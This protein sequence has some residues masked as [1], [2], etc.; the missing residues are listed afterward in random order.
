MKIP[1]KIPKLRRMG[2][3]KTLSIRYSEEIAERFQVLKNR[4]G[5]IS[6]FIED[7]VRNADITEAEL[8]A[9]RLLRRG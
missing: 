6:K 4:P 5:G 8:E 9:V 7:C 3:C 2:K 1:K